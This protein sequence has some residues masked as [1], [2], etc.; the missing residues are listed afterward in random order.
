MSETVRVDQINGRVDFAV[1]MIREDEFLAVL[2]RFDPRKPVFGGSQ[3]Y[4]LCTVKNRNGEEINIVVVRATDQHTSAQS[5]WRT[6]SLKTRFSRLWRSKLTCFHMT[7]A[8]K[9]G[10]G[11]SWI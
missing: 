6:A 10:A 4:K 9:P 2:D 3:I 7:T 8:L 5:L 1:L 11:V